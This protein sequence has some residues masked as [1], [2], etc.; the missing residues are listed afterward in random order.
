M[1]IVAG[2]FVI[3]IFGLITLT[4]GFQVYHFSMRY[5]HVKGFG[6]A[7]YVLAGTAGAVVAEF[8]FQILLIFVAAAHILTF[9][10]MAKTVAGNGWKCTVVFKVIGFIVCVAC[11]LPRSFNSNSYLSAICKAYPFPHFTLPEKI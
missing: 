4:T 8:L 11:S 7:G 3:A 1:G 2:A 10:V 6:D 9:S 5:P